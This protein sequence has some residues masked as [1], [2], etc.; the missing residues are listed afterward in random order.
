M[1]T[2]YQAVGT[3]GLSSLTF[4]QCSLQAVLLD[5][6]AMA[7]FN[8]M[9]MLN[10]TAPQR[11]SLARSLRAPS[12]SI[13]CVSLIES[14]CSCPHV[15]GLAL[16]DINVGAQRTHS[17]NLRGTCLRRCFFGSLLHSLTLT[18]S[19]LAI[20]ASIWSGNIGWKSLIH[21]A[22]EAP[23]G[24]IYLSDSTY[25]DN[26]GRNHIPFLF[27]CC[28]LI[29]LEIIPFDNVCVY[30]HRLTSGARGRGNHL[31]SM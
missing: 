14:H 25:V 28:C 20:A 6:Y 23:R 24:M 13:V 3:V 1:A 15:A 11:T 8:T 29:C 4:E 9:Y 12:G 19:L 30:S 2:A 17:F 21:Y 18:L 27:C 7:D 10:N 5:Q 31:R 26:Q 16:I 22:P